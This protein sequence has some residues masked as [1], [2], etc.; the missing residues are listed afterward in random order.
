MILH[1]ARDLAK[2]NSSSSSQHRNYV[3]KGEIQN[4]HLSF[5]RFQP[6]SS[7]N[8][9][10]AFTVIALYTRRNLFTKLFSY[11]RC[12]AS[13]A[14]PPSHPLPVLHSTKIAYSIVWDSK[15]HHQTLR[16]W[17]SFRYSFS[18]SFQGSYCSEQCRLIFLYEFLVFCFE[19]FNGTWKCA[20]YNEMKKKIYTKV[21]MNFF[22]LC[23]CRGLY[24]A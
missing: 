19:I 12:A 3:R 14:P 24:D 1:F 7:S 6:S 22:L 23:S 18:L 8:V 15:L 13:K 21:I 10:F 9:L 4:P 17:T 11:F 5:R 20:L 2:K 16:L